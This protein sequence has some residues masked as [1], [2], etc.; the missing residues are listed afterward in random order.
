M[1][2]YPLSGIISDP[3]RQS[4]PSGHSLHSVALGSMAYVPASHTYHPPST[5]RISPYIHSL[6]INSILNTSAEL[7]CEFA[8]TKE[9]FVL[10]PGLIVIS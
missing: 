9:M 2:Q 7:V 4:A 10:A 1:R 8:D 5:V 3:P 6:N